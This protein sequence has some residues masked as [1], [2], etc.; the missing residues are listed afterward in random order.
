MAKGV[1]WML[2]F[3]IAGRSLGLISTIIL[4]RLL[5]PADF[6]LVAMAMS[7]IAVLELMGYFSFDIMLIQKQ[8][9]GRVHY[10]TAWTFN[11]VFGLA[12]A[13]FLVALAHPTASFYNEPKLVIIMYLLATGTFIQ[14]CQN[15]GIVDF[16]KEMKFDR[17]FN[18]MFLTKV[19]GFIVTI[20]LAFW[21]RNYWAL[22]IGM[23]TMRIVGVVMSYI[24][25]P[26]RP[27]FSLAASKELFSFSKWIFVMNICDLLWLR[28]ADF[29]IGK[30]SGVRMLGLFSISYEISNLPTTELSAPINRAV[31]PGYAQISSDHNLLR[32]GFINVLSLIAVFAVPAGLGIAAIAPLLVAVFLGENWLDAIPLI[33]ILAIFGTTNAMLTNTGTVFLA[34]GKPNY[35]AMIAGVRVAILIPAL[36]I[37]TSYAG[38]I[39]AAWTYLGVSLLF[40][41][42]I[43]GLLFRVISLRPMQLV[44]EVWRPL[45][46]ASSMYAGVTLFINWADA[47]GT[48][49]LN[50]SSLLLAAVVLGAVIYGGI[51]LSLWQIAGRPTGAERFVADKLTARLAN[52]S[53][54]QFFR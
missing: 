49:M 40:M 15:I 31:F 38:V 25:H 7:I 41:P 54:M 3:K 24:M 5:M 18:F 34:V 21:L 19:S 27:G 2:L 47:A 44:A 9:A 10:D 11:V 32:Q 46:A 4:A 22:I 39:G 43:Y 53:L 51:L 14:G 8:D 50:M 35:L 37:F 17:E 6:G 36:L 33:A 28:S 12:A 29:I 1:A 20:P 30:I 48:G 42:I 52:S 13:L 26:Y 16:R 45:I 23:L